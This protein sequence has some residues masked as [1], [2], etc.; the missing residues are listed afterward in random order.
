MKYIKQV[1]LLFLGI[2]FFAG[3]EDD[4]VSYILQDISAPSNV[5]AVFD[6]TQDD[7]GV[8]TVTPSADGASSFE[9][10]FGDVENET[11]TVITPGDSAEHTYAEGEYT[12]RIIAKGMTGLTSEFV[13][14]IVISFRVPEN[15]EV[16]INQNSQDPKSF[17]VSATADNATLFMVYFGEVENEEP[18]SI[19][20]GQVASYTYQSP[21]DYVIRVVAKGAGAG[22]AEYSETVTVPD[23][24]DPVALPI[25]FDLPTVNYSLGTFNGASFEVVNN[26]DLS[27]ANTVAS[28]VGAITNSG[29]NYEG[30]AYDLGTPVDFS[31]TNKIITMKFWSNVS[32]PILL[33]FENGVNGERQNEVVV[34]HGGTGWEQLNFDF[35]N[36]ATKS[37][38]D[39]NQGVGEPFVPT[40][41]YGT[42]VI[43]VD[44]PGTTAGTFYI[45]DVEQTGGAQ[46]EVPITFDESGLDYS[47]GTFNGASYQVVDNPD[48][49]GVNSSASKVGAITN[50]GNNWEGGAFNL[51]VPVDFSGND[52]TILIKFWS[53]TPVPVLLKFEGGVNG[54]RQNEVVANHGGTGWELLVFDFATDATKSYIDGNQGVGEP[55]VPTGQYAT[56]VIFVDG[57]GTTAGTF[58]MD[59]IEQSAGVLR[60]PVSFDNPTVTYDFGTFNGASYQVVDNPDQ[61]GVNAVASKVGAITNSGNNWEGG[62]FNM[63][64]PVDFSGSNKTI[65]IKV[66]STSPVPVLLKFEGGVNGE[67]QNEVVANHGGTGWETLSFDFA[68]DATKSYIDG[69]QGVGE[70]FVP[71]GQ[72]GTLVLFIDGPGTTAGTFYIDDIEQQ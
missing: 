5:N 37:Y 33:K 22:T 39:G 62:A 43:F 8:V 42:V 7:T 48:Q 13:Q 6:V 3:C 1:L 49:S 32:V 17:E 47:F 9:I 27:G 53:T 30:G 55:F 54:E 50:S 18:V 59:D 69:N 61:S 16:T 36:D 20:P 60:V 63:D 51:D 56:M 57:P 41:Q 71:T 15:L 66:W 34:T 44:G 2:A 4:D 10:Y 28:K 14:N 65:A 31:G 19:M 26:P 24:N 11:P 38:I 29:N 68:N 23:A 25:T 45:D 12:V 58:Y 35:G 21:G 46:L 72:Y 40:G 67:R 52:K 70:P 64:V